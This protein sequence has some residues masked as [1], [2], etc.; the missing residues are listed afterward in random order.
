MDRQPYRS[1]LETVK[2]LP[3]AIIAK[4]CEMIMGPP[5][6]LLRLILRV[7]A[8]IAS[9]QWRGLVYGYGEDGEEI[10]VQWDYSGSEFSDWS[11]DENQQQNHRSGPGKRHSRHRSKTNNASKGTTGQSELNRRPSSSDDSRSWGVD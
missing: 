11:D 7:A 9:G 6:S 3:M 4:T 1:K 8:K 5:S 2:S 10:P